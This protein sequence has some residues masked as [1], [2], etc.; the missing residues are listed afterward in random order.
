MTV[1]QAQAVREMMKRLWVER[2]AA[3]A[4]GD[5]HE[6]RHIDWK[7]DQLHKMLLA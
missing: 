2:D 4:R 6:A 5:V 3:E 7:I 1:E